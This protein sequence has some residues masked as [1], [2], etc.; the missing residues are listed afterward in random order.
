MIVEFD[1][2][3][4]D[5]VKD[6]LLELQEH[7]ES[8][9]K[10]GF[11]IVTPNFRD[12]YYDKTITEINDNN[13]KIL[14]YK[15]NEEIVGLVVGLINNESVEEVGFRAPK[16]GRVTELVVSNKVRSNGIGSKLLK[17]MEEYL[18]QQGCEK[19]LL[20]VLS[21]NDRAKSFYE[22]HGYYSRVIDMI[23]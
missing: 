19:I 9:D 11:N 21:N 5:D 15:E 23:K 10:D 13:G 7:I 6:L 18:Y 14:L 3:Y 16:R 8:L 2:K 20:C 1:E 22:R 4:I 17:S 12:E